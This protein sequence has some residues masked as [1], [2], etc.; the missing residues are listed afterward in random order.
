MGWNSP[1]GHRGIRSSFVRLAPFWRRIAS[2]PTNVLRTGGDRWLALRST[3]HSAE[4]IDAPRHYE[5]DTGGVSRQKASSSIDEVGVYCRHGAKS[6]LATP[7]DFERI[8]ARRTDRLKAELLRRVKEVEVPVATTTGVAGLR[9]Y[10]LSS[11]PKAP[12]V[13]VTRA[14]DDST[15]T[16]VREELSGD[17]FSEINNVVNANSLLTEGRHQFS[18]APEI[19]YR[20]YAER[21]RVETSVDHIEL[22]A[23]TALTRLN[24]PVLYWLVLLPPENAGRTVRA[25][26]DNSKSPH[27][28]WLIR[29]AILLGPDVSAWLNQ[30]WERAWGKHSQPPGLLL[31]AQ[32][33]LAAIWRYRSTSACPTNDRRR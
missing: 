22:L 16:L 14:D 29:L 2:R 5:G 13:R 17:L 6:D 32:D 3:S 18:F 25:L 31:D 26:Y 33:R 20:I 7:E 1:N 28:T 21:Q 27:V 8:I 30:Q 24:A 23:R 19:Y 11:D 4:L 9:V 12:P 15:A 10:R